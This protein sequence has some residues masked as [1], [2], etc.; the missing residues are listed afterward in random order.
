MGICI[1]HKRL[2]GLQCNE[3]MSG[4]LLCSHLLMIR[5]CL[6]SLHLTSERFSPLTVS[7][8]ETLQLQNESTNLQDICS[9]SVKLSHWKQLNQQWPAPV[10]SVVVDVQTTVN[11]S[12]AHWRRLKNSRILNGI[13]QPLVPLVSE[14]I[15][16]AL[17]WRNIR[18]LISRDPGF[19]GVRLYFDLSLRK[20]ELKCFSKSSTIPLN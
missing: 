18:A 7:D 12:L 10:C 14:L 5:L 13:L 15:S 20:R 9:H 8:Q 17:F 19:W 1:F 3:T 16:G 2:N 4:Y 11:G 6:S